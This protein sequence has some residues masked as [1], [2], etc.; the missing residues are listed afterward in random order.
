M[1]LLETGSDA[2]QWAVRSEFWRSE[3]C[4]PVTRRRL[5]ERRLEPLVLCGHGV[6]LRVDG[7]A[8]VVRNGRTH[9]PQIP[10]TYRF[11]KGDPATPQRIVLLDGSG[12]VSFDVLDWLGEQGV[13][14]IRL[15][16]RGEV[17]TALGASGYAADPA[18]VRWQ[19]ETRA[20]P[21]RR[22][23]FACDLIGRK[24][25]A[26][27]Q[28]LSVLPACGKVD[29]VSQKLR[30]THSKLIA[31]PP[32]DLAALRGIEGGASAN[33]FAAWQGVSLKWSGTGKSPIPEAWRTIGPRAAVRVGKIPKNERATHPLNALLNYAYAALQSELQIEAISQGYD[34]TLGIMHHSYQGSE[35]Y[36]F[37]LMEPRRPRVD[38]AV[39]GLV[40]SQTLS[41]MDFTTRTDGAVRLSPQLARAVVAASATPGSSE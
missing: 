1:Q 16:W 7:G 20:D 13:A 3:G 31:S 2:H 5:R 32:A 4:R 29:L 25:D 34:P 11:F 18:K 8:L 6:C 35:A 37:D 23:A 12:S 22:L 24:I 21:V 41:P 36:T 27:I 30:N 26:A 19:T 33:Y 28:S 40:L 9:H 17:R 14:L 38:R 15:G 39:L 10:D